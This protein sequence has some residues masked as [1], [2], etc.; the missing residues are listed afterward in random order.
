MRTEV[1]MVCPPWDHYRAYKRSAIWLMDNIPRKM[2]NAK[3]AFAF[4]ADC[5]FKMSA[6]EHVVF[7]W[8]PN[9]FTEECRDYMKRLD[10]QYHQY[11]V[12]IRPKWKL[13]T[14]KQV[15]EYLMVFYKGKQPP[16]IEFAETFAQPFTGKVKSRDQKPDDAYAMIEARFPYGD[17]LQV[18]GFTRRP[19]WDV[20][21]RNLKK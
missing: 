6:P 10:Y 21:H 8:V 12:W 3:E 7:I 1:F 11:Y 2:M 15:A 14:T 19:G 16:K 17:K 18:Y 20:C 13:G 5:L 9:K 4:I